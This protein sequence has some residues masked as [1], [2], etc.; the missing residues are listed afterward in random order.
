M[1]SALFILYQQIIDS[2]FCSKIL[3]THIFYSNTV[4]PA[5]AIKA[6]TRKNNNL[7]KKW[8]KQVKNKLNW[9]TLHHFESS[10]LMIFID[11]STECIY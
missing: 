9:A 1:I 2:Q 10:N 3:D 7:I 6:G 8:L 5:T 11:I 4:L